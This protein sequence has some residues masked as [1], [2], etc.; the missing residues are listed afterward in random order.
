MQQL[1][2]TNRLMFNDL[3]KFI[4]IEY[5]DIS[6]CERMSY[7]QKAYLI[8]NGYMN[9][10]TARQIYSVFNEYINYLFPIISYSDR[11]NT[12]YYYVTILH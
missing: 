8:H 12:V 9:V 6:D 1:C 7:V 10:S 2:F 11:F 3:W 5:I 4:Y